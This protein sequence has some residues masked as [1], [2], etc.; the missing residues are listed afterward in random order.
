MSKYFGKN[1]YG[2]TNV[3]SHYADCTS[4]RKQSVLSSYTTE[5]CLHVF[6]LPVLPLGRIHITDECPYCGHYTAISHRTYRKTRKK[7]LAVMMEA[8]TADADNPDSTLNGLQ[9]LMVYNE[10]SWFMNV[11]NSYGRRFE[12]HMMVQQIIAQGL[13]RF[14]E[15]T[16]AI[17]Y[18]QKAIALGAGPRAE[19]LLR[20]CQSLREKNAA[21][22]IDKLSPKPESML[23]PYAFLM[24]VTATLLITLVYSGI[25][26]TRNHTAWL[27]SGL[28]I[29][30]SVDIDGKLYELDEYGIKRIKLRLGKHKM[31]VH[32]L[33]G[34]TEQVSFKYTT[35]RLRQKLENHSLVLN[36]D[37]MALLINETLDAD[38]RTKAY[39]FGEE[40]NAL[41]GINYPFSDFPLWASA[42]ESAQT[43]LYSHIPESHLEIVS[44][45]NGQSRNDD[46]TQYARRVLEVVPDSE[47]TQELLTVAVKNFSDEQTIE[48]LEPGMAAVP[49]R[50]N[51]HFYYQDFITTYKPEHDLQ[52]EYALLCEAHPDVPEY[53]YLL[54]RIVQN[55]DSAKLLFEKAERGRGC[56]GMGYW[57]I[58][59]DQLCSGRFSE[60]LPN[61]AKALEKSPESKLFNALDHRIHLALQHY[62]VLLNEERDNLAQNPTNGMHVAELVKYLTLL[63]EH[64]AADEAVRNF[65]GTG[66]Q[67]GSYFSAARFYAVG[68]TTDYLE[69]LS[70]SGI[71]DTEWQQLLHAGDIEEAQVQL[72]QRESIDY[73]DH[74][75]L[76]CAARFHNNSGIALAE[77]N[78][79]VSS[80]DASTGTEHTIA[81]MLS[82]PSAPKVKD[83]LALRIWPENKAI[84]C[85]ALG[86]RFPDR[87]ET[88]FKLS[89]TFNH[90]LEFP[91]LILKKW[92]RP[93]S[94]A[95]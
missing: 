29:A 60:A 51:W 48:Y 14:G 35:S 91:Q 18:C 95:Q 80:L 40:I 59:R 88:F 73:M 93:A 41:T 31:Q 61:A 17:I 25:S 75:L 37:A 19:E 62:N 7:D 79:A 21:Y 87:R 45:L 89:H 27:V 13:C 84:L 20:L 58:A 5:N 69:S 10:K 85:A 15:Y 24:A 26:A 38:Q 83:V 30:Y 86:Y 6:N 57:A 72:H 36:P 28:P 74:L 32:G 33:S 1:F 68:N 23:K 11:E 54:G 66:N 92:T 4:C 78:D 43:R 9:T 70:A 67:W 81:T 44:M 76:Y 2:K 8:F 65:E 77:L 94:R 49:P 55:R 63:G 3:V 16:E 46:A 56:G 64:S 82:Q 47:E 22:P 71:G 50:L 12:T 53:Y 34:D 52:T 90:S 39:Q 42:K